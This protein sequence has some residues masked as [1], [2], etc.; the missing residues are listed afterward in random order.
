M[1]TQTPYDAAVAA[2]IL[3]A[4]QARQLAVF[5]ASQPAQAAREAVASGMPAP[6][7]DLAH[8]LWYAGASIII[9][10]M[11][12][13][14]TLAFSQ[15][16]G[17]ALVVT[18]LLYAVAFTL[19]GH[20]LWHRKGLTTPGGLMIAIAV[21]MAP[22]IVFGIQDMMHWWN[23]SAKP[24]N[25]RD[26]YIWIKGGWLPM[27]IATLI[28]ALIAIRFYPFGFIAMI[29]AVALWF[30]S[31][32]LAPWL[33]GREDIS[34]ALRR[35]VSMWFGLILMG[36]AWFIDLRQRKADYAF[37]LHL[38]GIVA[39][40]G[41]VT[42]QSS[43]SEFAKFLYCLMNLGLMGFAVFLSRRVY[44]VFGA[45]GVS[46]YLGHLASKVFA[47]SLLFPFALSLLGLGMIGLGLVYYRNAGRVAAWLERILPPALQRLRPTPI[48]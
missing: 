16:G 3:T 46:I 7:F 13:F 23:D 4:E 36:F 27:E 25:Y 38:A 29:A 44:A 6:R 48:G 1:T 17:G 24:G 28:A 14:S 11:G 26:F 32:D 43:S 35:R 45:L 9:G 37:W 15:M 2:G 39:F 47:N 33:A 19:T 18:G 12:L 21:S 10:A 20:H 8:L 31:M 40:W 22:M 5:Q 34:W 30:M 41:A 42:M